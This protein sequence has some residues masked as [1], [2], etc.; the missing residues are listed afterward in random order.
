M[1]LKKQNNKKISSGQQHILAS[2]EEGWDNCL[3]YVLAPASLS[4]SQ[5]DKYKDKKKLIVHKIG[6]R[7]QLLA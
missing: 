2:P 7:F 6:K 1:K 3:P 4:A 5:E